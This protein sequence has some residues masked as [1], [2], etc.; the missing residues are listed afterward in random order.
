MRRSYT[1]SESFID[2]LKSLGC[3]LYLPL[4]ENDYHDYIGGHDLVFTGSGSMSWDSNVGMTLLT[5]P[6]SYPTDIATLQSDTLKPESFPT[7]ECTTCITFKRKSTNKYGDF[8]CMGR[9]NQN[10]YPNPDVNGTASMASWGDGVHNSGLTHSINGRT[11]FEDGALYRQ[12]STSSQRPSQWVGY[13][14]FIN[15][16]SGLRTNAQ[17]Y[18]ANIMIFNRVLT[19]DEYRKVSGY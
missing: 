8:F 1:V 6:G 13:N 15:T 19:L 3:V 18:Y 12:D 4:G 10:L 7:D 14:W 2:Y 16:V 5:A 9:Y 17:S 11:W